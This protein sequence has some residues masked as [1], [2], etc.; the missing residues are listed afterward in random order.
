[1][2]E[3]LGWDDT[4]R[5]AEVSRY[6]QRVAAELE[7]QAAPDDDAAAAIRERVRDPRVPA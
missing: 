1:M 4:T 3:A 2:G 5:A 7:A 6:Q